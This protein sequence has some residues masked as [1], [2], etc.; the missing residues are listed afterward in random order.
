MKNMK[1]FATW[2]SA[3]LLAVTLA[4][5]CS[6]DDEQS[7]AFET[8]SLYF[9]APGATATVSFTATKGLVRFYVSGKPAGWEDENVVLDSERMQ[10]TITMPEPA[11]D[12]SVATSGT[13]TLN[14]YT[15]GNSTKLATLFVGIVDQQQLAGPANSF[16]AAQKETNYSF[17][18]QRADGSAVQAARVGL[19][20]QSP[21][22]LIQYLHLDKN[23]RASFYIGADATRTDEI[24]RGNALI[25]A[26]D[27]E[28]N[29]L[30]SWHIWSCN[31][32]PEADAVVWQNGYR[33]MNRN[34]GALD[35]ANETNDQKFASYGLF[36]QWGRKDPF[37]GPADY[38]ASNGT[39]A[40]IYSGDYAMTA[41]TYVESS[42][43]TGTEAYANA[44]P[45]TFITGVAENGYDWRWNGAST[46]WTAQNDPCPIGWRVAPAGAFEGLG[47]AG[48]A[49]EADY[50]AYGWTLTDGAASSYFAAA[51]RRVY[52]NG[53]IQNIHEPAI[54]GRANTAEESQPWAG[55]YWTR[56]S[57]AGNARAFYFG[58]YKKAAELALAPYIDA[59]RAN[60]QSVRCVKE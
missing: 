30:W 35:N 53:Y 52:L 32:D 46:E 59:H 39:S 14:G 15:S 50:E 60:G 13:I 41:I 4:V 40:S 49:T 54:I 21:S 37:V 56:E 34:L 57:A 45:L 24:L 51:G 23:N 26:Y 16:I 12:G 11:D 20:W 33:M 28:D 31:Y 10:L 58:Y 18:L 2:I 44:N 42:A 5:G 48:T 17:A 55:N 7:I 9:A 3:A 8:P 43:E 6:K 36:Y 27:A 25:G 38:K 22:K 29:L 19:I 47:F 1:F